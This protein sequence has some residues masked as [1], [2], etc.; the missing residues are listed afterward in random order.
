[1]D[2]DLDD[3]HAIYDHLDHDGLIA[4]SNQLALE[5]AQAQEQIAMLRPSVWSFALLMEQ[6]LRANDHK[7][8]WDACE[9]RDLMEGILEE[10]DELQ[11]CDPHD[12]NIAYEA[13]DMANYAMMYTDNSFHLFKAPVL[14]EQCIAS[15]SRKIQK[16]T[17]LHERQRWAAI[18]E[19][20]LNQKNEDGVYFYE[21]EDSAIAIAAIKEQGLIRLLVN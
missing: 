11:R 4:H 16:A 21:D 8:G 6:R 15:F 3:T 5:L 1:M 19:R 18:C 20:V 9:P 12:P 17:L 10:L 2:I 14:V 13:A 7:G